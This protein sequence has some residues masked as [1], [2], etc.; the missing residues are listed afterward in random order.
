M[1]VLCMF[2]AACSAHVVICMEVVRVG[3]VSCCVD[4]V[5]AG[6]KFVN[7]VY[8]ACVNSVCSILGLG[9]VLA[10]LVYEFRS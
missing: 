4:S 7:Y 2:I 5:R 9:N 3:S 6:M 8:N 1:A 10:R